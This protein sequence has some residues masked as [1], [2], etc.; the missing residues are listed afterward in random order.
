MSFVGPEICGDLNYFSFLITQYVNTFLPCKILKHYLIRYDCIQLQAIK[1]ELTSRLNRWWVIF[2]TEPELW[3]QEARGGGSPSRPS[4]RTGICLSSCSAGPGLCFRP[5][6]CKTA[7]AP[8]GRVR[9]T[10]R[11]KACG[12]EGFAILLLKGYCPSRRPKPCPT[13]TRSCKGN[14]VKEWSSWAQ[15]HPKTGK[16]GVSTAA[17]GKVHIPLALSPG[18]SIPSSWAHCQA[19][20]V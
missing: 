18:P 20:R 5:C 3:K 10:G 13:A 1:N 11:K 8:A 19:P 4:R 14:C 9:E 12:P 16:R 2:L 15:S 7:A 6:T 17:T